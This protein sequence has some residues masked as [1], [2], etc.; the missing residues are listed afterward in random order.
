MIALD[1][2][3]KTYST[4]VS[5]LNGISMKIKK[6]EFVFVVGSSGSGKTTLF[7]LLLKELEPTS[8]TIY[9]NNK[10]IGRLRRRKIPRM[11]RGIG[12]VFQDFRLLK[13]R[14]VYD[15]IAF[16]QRVVGKSSRQIKESVP[17]LLSL[18]GLSDKAKAFPNELSGGEQQRVALARALANN[19]P[20]LLADE[21]TGNLD[22][23]NA[24]EIMKLL[25]EINLRGTTVI[26]VTHN[27]DIVEQM[28]K[29]V[30]TLSNGVIVSDEQKG[31]YYED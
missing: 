11:R 29:R 16:A 4:G 5:A 23:K 10:N 15:N 7:K 9:I 3:Y 6:G 30:I 31:G 18:V 13:D 26:V 1:N 27:K 8:G 24:W 20:V 28:Q 19:P 25:E 2:V 14:T 22:P 17:G 12:V 21:P